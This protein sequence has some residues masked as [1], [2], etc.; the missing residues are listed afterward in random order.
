MSGTQV[1]MCENFKGF[2]N[3]VEKVSLVGVNIS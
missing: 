1:K 2:N 3:T